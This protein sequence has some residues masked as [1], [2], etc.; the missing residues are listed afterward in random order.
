MAKK[1]NK[2]RDP[3]HKVASL[4]ALPPQ[5]VL[6][7]GKLFLQQEKYQDAI[8]CFKQLLKQQESPEILQ[9]LE[10]AYL[11]RI[12]S[13]AAKSM[14]KEATVLLEI[15]V[16]RWPHADVLSLRL[17]L[18]LQAGRFGEA[19]QL[20][21]RCGKQMA[22]DVRQRLDALFGALLLVGVG[23][24]QPKDFPEDSPVA[25]YYPAA[26]SAMEAVFAS[27][28]EKGQESLKQISFRSPYR[29]LRTLLTG[30]LHFHSDKDLGCGI[31]RKID[32]DSPYFRV[33]ARG[34]AVAD[35]P[36]IFLQ[37]LAVT[38][39]HE[40]Q[41]FCG[42]YGVNPAQLPVFEALSRS[43][44]RP[45]GLYKIVSRHENC[46]PK[47]LRI[48]LLRN[49][50]PFC[51]DQALTVLSRSPDFTSIEKHR[52]FALAAEKG[53]ATSFAVEFWDDYLG[54]TDRSDTL[55]YKEIAMVMRY[56]AKLKKQDEYA[57]SP[58]HVL[59]K[60]LKSLEYDPGHAATWLDAAEYA[61]RHVSASRSYAI[62]ND[63][64]A[65]LPENVPILVAAMQACGARNAHKKA[66]SLAKRILEIDPINT[67]VLDFLVES[68][69]EHGRKLASQKKWL[70]AEK[71]LQSADTRVKALRYRGR[72]RICLGMVLLLQGKEEGLEYIA[73]GKEEN[74]SPFFGH[75]LT[76]LESRLY[77]LP[78]GRHQEFD[79]QLRQ[80]ED[81]APTIDRG[82]F[83]RLINWLLSFD[84]EQWLML[85]EVCQCLTNTF[86]KAAILPWSRDEGLLVCKAL[87]KADQIA[88]LT[89]TSETLQKKY[90]EDL[91]F[92]VWSL[93]ADTRKNKKRPSMKAVDKLEDLLYQLERKNRLDFVEYIED[94]LDKGRGPR[95]SPFF[96]E[97]EDEDEEKLDDIFDFGPF[98]IPK[99][100]GIGEKSPPKPKTK[101]V[102]GK[103][104]NLFDDEL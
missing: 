77:K 38:P 59:E 85:K 87:E 49:I 69:L 25:R 76:S 12:R 23:G 70:L 94:I 5:E 44:G 43:D 29:D 103:Q 75:V 21:G 62:I 46:F 92:R 3:K 57:Y 99:I 91:E 60:L 84:G 24:L 58:A 48:T 33:A 9:A 31:L 83:L 71:E 10:Q 61:K 93:L 66:S 36:E 13:L 37:K 72:H 6:A 68:R 54:N 74:G 11:G 56:Q 32:K 17:S 39:K 52:I 42:Q 18:L 73:A 28:E 16:E 34:L 15:V 88:A 78:K 104:L 14:T 96:Y 86:A 80:V 47:R 8:L 45:L 64:V 40:Q 53:G 95:F 98:K 79:R 51:K 2:G 67:S 22:S 1:K 102:G 20:Y 41:Q 90:P 81:S 30:L 35:T 50:L 7:K 27:E 82:E 4:G 89:K 65:K 55:R 101:P 63:A 19:V 100:L 26:L 97:D